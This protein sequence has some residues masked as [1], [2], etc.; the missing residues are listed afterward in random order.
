VLT[1]HGYTVIGV[2][3]GQEALAVLD[4]DYFDL[5]ISDIMMPVMDGYELVR[6]LRDVNDMTPVLMIAAK[7]AY[8][9]MR[10]P[11]FC[12]FGRKRR[13]TE[14]VNGEPVNRKYVDLKLNLD[15]RICDG[16]YC[17]AAIKRFVRVLK[18]P[19][20]LDLPPAEVE[21]DIP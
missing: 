7:D 8:D 20:V 14:L 11:V 17:A 19:E 21:R 3:D 4:A 13:V 1:K 18:Y 15:E 2:S 16:Y 12:A 6:Q 9:D 5:I 10:I